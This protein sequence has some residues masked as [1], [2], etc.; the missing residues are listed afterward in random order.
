MG[1]GAIAESGGKVNLNSG[2]SITTGAFNAIGLGASGANSQVIATANI[3]VVMNGR[4]ALGV[5]LH[6][7]GQVS[8]LNNSVLQ[9][10]A[11]N[12]VGVSVDNT[13]VTLG[14]IG[15]GLTINFNAT[16]LA[17]QAG[18][19]GVVA[20]N[21]GNISLENLT[22]QGVGAGAGA[23][24]RPGSTINLS[25]NSL[26]NINA[27][28][29]P[30]YYTLQ[31]AFLITASGSV[32]SIFSVTS[33]LPIGG[34]LSNG[35]IINSTGTTVNVTST[36]G[37][38]AY[39]A[40]NSAESFINM[41]NNIINTTGASSFG[42]EAGENGRITGSNTTVT[43]SGG[44]A[45]L[46][47]QAF[48]TGYGSIA[49]TNSRAEAQGV[50]TAGL[51]SLNLSSGFTTLASLTN[52]YLTS[53]DDAVILGVGGPLSVTSTGS[54]LVAQNGLLI[55]AQFNASAPQQTVV[56]LSATQSQLSGNAH[57]DS[58]SKVNMSLLDNTFWS[59]A[60]LDATNIS[61][62]P[63][64][65]W[66]VTANS[67][68]TQDIHNSGLISYTP[69][70]GSFKTITT[71]NYIGSGGRI[72]LNTYLGGDSSPSD[73]LII[74]AGSATG[75]TGLSVQNADGPGALTLGNGILVVQGENGGITVPGAFYLSTPAVAG[76]FEY[77]LYRS[78]LDGSSSENWYLRSLCPPEIPNC[79]PEPPPP[80]PVPPSP[81]PPSYRSEIGL[82]PVLPAM[83]LLYGQA[84][85]DTLH[86]RVGQGKWPEAQVTP[87]DSAKRIWGRVVGL[88]GERDR[89]TSRRFFR[90]SNY[91]Y[92]FGFMQIGGD[93]FKR[94][95]ENGRRDHVGIYGAFGRGTGNVQRPG[96]FLG[97]NQFT[98]LSIG[99]YWTLYSAKEA[100]IDTLLQGTHYYDAA[101]QS[102]RLNPVTTKG[103]GLVA[104]VEG[105]YPFVIK[106][107]W[108]LE[109][110]IQGVYETV[111]LSSG[112][113]IGAIIQFN[114]AES[115]VGRLGVRLA[116]RR[117]INEGEKILTTWFRP[118]FWYQFKGNPNAA[119]SS[120]YGFIPFQSQLE[121]STLEL[122][123]GTTLDLPKNLSLYANGSYGVGLNMHVTTYDG[124]VGFK[125]KLT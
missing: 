8:L 29:A 72:N 65:T 78:S 98:A 83:T 38:G 54:T 14:T 27:N 105:G 10:N 96:L 115:V 112:Q 121:G 76:P 64:S 122:N 90:S 23:W 89:I 111:N 56:N 102:Y 6:D 79:S 34:L 110:Q 70:T 18:G 53:E 63:S 11:S 26:I 97:S 48:N 95:K 57:A 58:Q 40:F 84:L 42:I 36:N 39:A 15:R 45:A 46:F 114:D 80:G 103:W 5:Y 41:S 81:A 117:L 92:N 4:G 116:H 101:S 88:H 55:D 13:S 86:Q 1:H 82:Y 71:Q 32:G 108:I 94:E 47:V 50:N 123:L 21:T 16:P 125:V 77:N 9:M 35:G 109:P 68:V 44:G 62:D 12:S 37:V 73:L 20:F 75:T 87:N 60:S 119:F 124:R 74:N 51:A 107:D 30:T 120:A 49:L 99:G 33:G 100:Y 31:T 24:A 43:S 7:G 19:T 22:V 91:D 93:L 67:T 28:A 17:G 2:T 118:N 106:P 113:D 85:V 69:P 52:S 61:L 66:S 104:S 59:G 25:G 3:P